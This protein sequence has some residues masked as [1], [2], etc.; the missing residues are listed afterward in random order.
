[1]CVIC[2]NICTVSFNFQTQPCTNTEF[3]CLNSQCIKYE[4]M[5]DGRID[6]NDGSDEIEATCKV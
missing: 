6:C 4:K 3:E 1:M 5:C 2:I